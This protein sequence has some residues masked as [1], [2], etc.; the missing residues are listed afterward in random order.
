[1]PLFCPN[2][3]VRLR[4]ANDLT[5]RR[6]IGTRTAAAFYCCRHHFDIDKY[7]N[8]EVMHARAFLIP[9]PFLLLLPPPTH[10][11]LPHF[12]L[13]IFRHLSH[14]SS[15]FNLSH[16]SV[17]FCPIMYPHEINGAY[18]DALISLYPSWR[19]DAI[20]HDGLN[21]KMV[22]PLVD[23]RLG[24]TPVGTSKPLPPS[25]APAPG[26]PSASQ[27]PGLPSAPR[28]SGLPSAPQQPY[29]LPHQRPGRALPAVLAALS[30]TSPA[31]ELALD[32]PSNSPA[33]RI[34]TSL[35]YV[36]SRVKRSHEISAYVRNTQTANVT[37]QV[38][39]NLMTLCPCHLKGH[40]CGKK[41]AC[42]YRSDDWAC[43][44]G[45]QVSKHFLYRIRLPLLT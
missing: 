36:E 31:R 20:L 15:S 25:P 26:L 23:A 34:V 33:R 14:S 7:S 8:K 39:V 4:A 6:W 41:G 38:W 9:N 24:M 40:H 19:V 1:M 43:T 29:L 35:P 16:L 44:D 30:S 21:P 37:R 18:I 10:H 42:Q 27:Q 17:I 11:F 32:L 12:L 45:F 5:K 3:I 28:Q 22:M 13:Y 2:V